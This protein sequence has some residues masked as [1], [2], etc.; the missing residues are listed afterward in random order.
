MSE[1][2]VRVH[3]QAMS[4]IAREFTE[5]AEIVAKSISAL[6]S[7]MAVLKDGKQWV[8]NSAD[9][10]YREME[11]V[12][13]QLTRLQMSFGDGSFVSRQIFQTMKKADLDSQALLCRQIQ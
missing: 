11:V 1:K 10:F 2:Q 3:S 9:A 8:G 7:Q 13:R 5:N 6:R 12:Y 4:H